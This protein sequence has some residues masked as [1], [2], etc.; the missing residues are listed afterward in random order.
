MAG[1]AILGNAWEPGHIW[2]SAARR[3]RHESLSEKRI[4]KKFLAAGALALA[5][6]ALSQ[7]QAPAWVNCQFGV[8]VNWHY[9]SGGNNFCWGVFRNG[10]PPGAPDCVNCGPN[11]PSCFYKN[12]H[13]YG[14]GPM[15]HGPDQGFGFGPEGP[16][17]TMPAPAAPAA[18]VAPA[19]PTPA[20]E[21]Q[22]YWF[23]T[24]AYRN[25]NYSPGYPQSGYYR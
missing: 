17:M 18:P 22:V 6:V 25:V 3:A 12:L 5:V 15:A 4:M 20:A 23:N 2:V 16:A 21:N 14:A 10:Q 24:P 13:Y 9:Q 1:C 7:Q 11:C 8:G 19:A